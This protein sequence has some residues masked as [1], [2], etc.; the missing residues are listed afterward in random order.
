[1]YLVIQRHKKEIL[2]SGYPRNDI[3]LNQ[4]KKEKILALKQKFRL[5]ADKKIFLYAPTWRDDKFYGGGWYDFAT[6]L[7]FEALYRAFDG[8]IFLL[9]KYH[10]LVKSN[11]DFAAYKKWLRVCDFSYDISELYLV[12]DALIT[13]YSSVMF[14]YSLLRRPMFFFAYDFR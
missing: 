5:P 8:E 7:D 1:M 12:S 4:N 13:D 2:K 3:L 14:D 11:T 10:Y 9:I 6:E